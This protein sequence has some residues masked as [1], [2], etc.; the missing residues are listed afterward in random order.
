MCHAQPDLEIFVKLTVQIGDCIRK[1]LSAH[2]ASGVGEFM[3]SL[4]LFVTSLMVARTLIPL[5]QSS[6]RF[7]QF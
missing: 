1:T 7:A 2:Y 3:Q 6:F 4:P 5:L